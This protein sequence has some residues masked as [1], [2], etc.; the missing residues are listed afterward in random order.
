MTLL[1]ALD[2]GKT[3]GFSEWHYDAITPLTLLDHGQISGGSRGLIAWWQSRPEPNEVVA[4]IFI[5]DHRTMSPDLTPV[6]IEGALDVLFPGWIGQRN[7]SKLGATDEC[8]RRSDLWIV[9]QQHSRD[10]IRHALS[11]MKARKHVPTIKRYWPQGRHLR[12]V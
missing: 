12:T 5:D 6:R 8:L 4:E 2:P 11:Y 7:F 9:G 3:T 10:S 1:R